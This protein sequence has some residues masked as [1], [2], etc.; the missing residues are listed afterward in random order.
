MAAALCEAKIIFSYRGRKCFTLKWTLNLLIWSQTRYQL[1]HKVV[2]LL[3]WFGFTAEFENVN[4]S[5]FKL[6]FSEKVPTPGIGP[7]G[8]D[9]LLTIP[10]LESQ[11]VSVS[12][13]KCNKMKIICVSGESNLGLP[14]GRREFYHWTTIAKLPNSF[15]IMFIFHKMP[16][17]FTKH[18]QIINQ[19]KF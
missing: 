4:T 6:K 2:A 10:V 16:N 15:V 11:F 9:N 5:C 18:L 19:S 14:R 7:H 12:Q 3:K 1:R 17:I 8:S 13:L